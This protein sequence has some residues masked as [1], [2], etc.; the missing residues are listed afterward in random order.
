MKSYSR[1]ININNNKKIKQNI[2][3]SNKF[4]IDIIVIRQ[5]KKQK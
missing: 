2:K 3:N 5:E 1:K 4:I